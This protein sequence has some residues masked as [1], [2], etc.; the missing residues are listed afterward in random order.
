MLAGLSGTTKARWVS[1]LCPD[2]DTH[3]HSGQVNLQH[4]SFP[5]V[6]CGTGHAMA[7]P[8]CLTSLEACCIKGALS[9]IH[10]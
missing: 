7:H 9:K 10:M 8:N 4:K 6:Q 1:V 3:V 5:G 2:S